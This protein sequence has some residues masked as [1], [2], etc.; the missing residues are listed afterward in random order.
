MVISAK[1]RKNRKIALNR[2]EP[3]IETNEQQIVKVLECPE[4]PKPV[5]PLCPETPIYIPDTM[6]QFIYNHIVESKEGPLV[7]ARTR[8]KSWVN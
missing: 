8:M 6:E 7:I 4:C 3:D 1:P 5:C 2:C